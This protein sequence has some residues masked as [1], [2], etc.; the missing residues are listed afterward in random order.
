MLTFH[1]KII[2][3]DEY[4]EILHASAVLSNLFM[5]D[6]RKCLGQTECG[7]KNKRYWKNAE[8]LQT[9]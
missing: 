9:L 2:V 6:S 4:S 3:S 5:L 1:C 8:P 7:S